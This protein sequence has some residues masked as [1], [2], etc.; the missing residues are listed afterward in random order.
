MM[1]SGLN[2]KTVEVL[3]DVQVNMTLDE[4]YAVLH[5]SANCTSVAMQKLRTVIHGALVKYEDEIRPQTMC[6]AA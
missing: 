1:V 6:E 2:T 5:T 4:A 3:E